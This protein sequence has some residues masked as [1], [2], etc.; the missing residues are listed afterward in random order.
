MAPLPPTPK[1]TEINCTL[2]DEF[3]PFV[4]G[5]DQKNCPV[6]VGA[7]DFYASLTV[8]GENLTI[9]WLTKAVKGGYYNGGNVIEGTAGNIADYGNGE[10]GVDINYANE[11]GEGDMVQF[12]IDGVKSAWMTTSKSN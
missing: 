11:Y 4:D 2:A 10:F 5:W 6:E 9:D 3:V 12:E 1:I 8:K 7:N